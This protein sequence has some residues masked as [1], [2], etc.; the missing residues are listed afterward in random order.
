MKHDC[1]VVIM[2]QNRHGDGNTI[3]VYG[4]AGAGVAF[5]GNKSNKKISEGGDVALM[6]FRKF[7]KGAV[8]QYFSIDNIEAHQIYILYLLPKQTLAL[9]LLNTNVKLLFYHHNI[10]VVVDKKKMCQTKKKKNKVN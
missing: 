3:T 8:N 5:I 6:L 1:D 9:Y 10:F 4:T 7:L 2:M